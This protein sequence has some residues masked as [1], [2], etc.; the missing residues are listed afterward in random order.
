MQLSNSDPDFK[1]PFKANH[2]ISGFAVSP[3]AA[4][5]AS[6]LKSPSIGYHGAHQTLSEMK[7]RTLKI[8]SR[9]PEISKKH[10]MDYKKANILAQNN[11]SHFNDN[12][13]KPPK[14]DQVDELGRKVYTYKKP[15]ECPT[16]DNTL[17][18][19]PAGSIDPADS[20]SILRQLKHKREFIQEYGH[21]IPKKV[22][23]RLR[24]EINKEYQEHVLGPTAPV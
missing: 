8:S 1:G 16:A 10:S 11:E 5:N 23:K 13:V 2:A 14:P 21:I 7:L 12:Y 15:W 22:Q 17:S 4:S 18:F 20:Q 19:S 6:W 9:R 3:K 24:D